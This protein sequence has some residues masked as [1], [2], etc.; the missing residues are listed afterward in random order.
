MLL[1]T[2]LHIFYAFGLMIVAC[3]FGQRI[4][5]AFNECME[6]IDQFDWYRLPANIQRMLPL[7]IAFAQQ[8][9]SETSDVSEVRHAIVIHSNM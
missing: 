6:M 4:N 7:V 9:V 5:L 2:M 3:E 8:P 1:I